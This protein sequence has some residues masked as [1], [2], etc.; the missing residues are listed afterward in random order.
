[1]PALP[2][3]PDQGRTDRSADSAHPA[4]AAASQPH[5]FESPLASQL[6]AWDLLPPHTMLV[7]RRPIRNTGK[8]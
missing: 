3:S 5:S 7:R 8:T 4:E 2:M 6:P 1:M